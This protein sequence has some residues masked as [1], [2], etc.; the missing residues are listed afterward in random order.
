MKEVSGASRSFSESHKRFSG[1]EIGAILLFICGFF[2]LLSVII[3]LIGIL[4]HDNFIWSLLGVVIVSF[5]FISIIWGTRKIQKQGYIFNPPV[6]FSNVNRKHVDLQSNPRKM[7]FNE[8][9]NRLYISTKNS[10]IE[11]DDTTNKTGNEIAIKDPGHM[12]VDH[13]KNRLFVTLERGIAVID[14]SSNTLIKNI[15][16]EFRF[17]QL[18]INF[19]TNILY[20]I[21]LDFNCI[22][23]IDCSS[24]FLVD[25]IYCIGYPRTLTLNQ[26]TNSIFVGNSDNV[27][28]IID[29]SKN[30][31]IARIHLPNPP[32]NRWYPVTTSLNE[33]YV[34]PSNNILYI[35]EDVI[36]P[37]NEGGVGLQ[38]LFFKIHLNGIFFEHY[39]H[40]PECD[41]LPKTKRYMPHHR[42]E[43]ILRNRDIF[44][45]NS[46][47]NDCFI[48]NSKS[49]L[50][51]L[52]DIG[53]KKLD[54]IDLDNKILRSFE[55]SEH[56][57]AIAINPIGNEIYLA[58]S[59]YISNSLDIFFVQKQ[60]TVNPPVSI[61]NSSH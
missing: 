36:G 41:I 48:V 49:G 18:C 39:I 6:V 20:A 23:I 9:N 22:Y 45:R 14:T 44:S 29:S 34:D 53:R 3:F 24:H 17:G 58:N 16:G 50:Q 59:G 32:S 15:F 13:T 57:N 25:K 28:T 56:C 7:I 21:N 27:V 26:N 33:L 47:L 4:N 42:S 1:L 11:F 12:A 40:S 2:L 35:K 19:S 46:S 52:T 60:P 55:I 5:V 10:I 31:V 51:Y 54:E 38:T 37:P 8:G 43:S 61:E 30:K